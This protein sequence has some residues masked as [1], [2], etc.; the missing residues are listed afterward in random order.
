[1]T[2]LF[3]TERPRL[4]ALAY[5]FLGSRA[6]AADTVQDA[7]LRWR[8]ARE[9]RDPA[10]WLTTVTSR[11]ALDRLRSARV[12]RETYPGVWL[13]EPVVDA[14]SPEAEMLRRADLSMAFLFLIEKLGPE[15]R[16]AF[17]LREVFDHSYR[18]IATALE[19]TEAACRQM[20]ARAR[21][22]VRRDE[23]R[24]PVDRAEFDS[25]LGR[26]VDALASGDAESLLNLIAPD[27]VLYGD[28]GGKALSVVNPLVGSERIVRF[29]LGLRRK[30]QGQYTVEPISVNGSP[31]FRLCRFG[32]PFGVGAYDIQDGR[33]QSFY[34]V[35]NPDKLSASR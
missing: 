18:E 28:G 33:I 2:D 9:L 16:A 3:E 29:L 7:W 13:P 8:D 34:N 24:R 22:R 14:P 25:V 15:E 12:R 20:V 30:Y 23:V 17:V 5:A 11:L 19:K 31:G 1:V 4:F 27:A 35:M 32:E 10:A 21:E 6:E 26:Y